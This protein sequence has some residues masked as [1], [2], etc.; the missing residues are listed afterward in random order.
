MTKETYGCHTEIDNVGC[1]TV[2]ADC[3]L[4]TGVPEDCAH[5][6]GLERKEDCPYW[7]TSKT[8]KTNSVTATPTK[9]AAIE[10]LL[11]AAQTAL[12]SHEDFGCSCNGCARL[13]KAIINAVKAKVR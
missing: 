6:E 1:G 10:E 11:A 12:S 2:Y 3:V 8:E 13:R 7:R 4:E 9:K 5:S